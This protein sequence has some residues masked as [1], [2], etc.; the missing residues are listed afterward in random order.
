MLQRFR[1]VEKLAELTDRTSAYRQ[2][3]KGEDYLP[4]PP[5]DKGNCAQRVSY[6]SGDKT[7]KPKMM[8]SQRK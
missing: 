5:S 4:Y 7:T 1:L 2:L 8:L 3:A 6:G